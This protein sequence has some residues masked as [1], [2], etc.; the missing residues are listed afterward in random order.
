MLDPAIPKYFSGIRCCMQCYAMLCYAMLCY[1]TLCSE[2]YGRLDT[3]PS[4]L[5]GQDKGITWLAIYIEQTIE[6]LPFLSLHI[7][8]FTEIFECVIQSKHSV[9]GDPA[10]CLQ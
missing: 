9:C 8:L 4:R 2:N 10:A 7:T 3:E 1:V 6:S 5:H